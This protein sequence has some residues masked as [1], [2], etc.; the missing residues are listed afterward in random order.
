MTEKTLVDRVISF[1]KARK[2][3]VE[4]GEVNCIPLPFE[5]FRSEIPGIEQ[6]SYYLVS[7]ST[8]SGKSQLSN[9]LFIYNTIF[10]SFYNRDKV[11]PKI[12]YYPLE[13][14]PEVITLR[15]MSFLLYT[16]SNGKCRISP[17]DLKSTDSSKPLP[18]SVIDLLESSLYKEI[19][20]Y[21]ESVIEFQTSRNPTGV[22]KELK[23]YAEN[24]GTTYYKSITTKDELGKDI[25]RKKFDYYTPN[26][27]NEYVFII[28]DHVSLIET[29]KGLSL[30]ESINKLSEYLIIFRNRYNYIPVVVQQ[31]SLETTNLDAFKANKIRPTM[32]GLSD[33]KYTG[34]DCTVMLG[35]T[36]PHSFEIPAYLGYDITKLLGNA[37][38]L[39]V[40]L[41][42]N[43][44]SNGICPLYFDGAVNYFKEMPLP[45][46][47]ESMGNIY[48][49]LQKI[50]KT[51]VSFFSLSIKN[52]INKLQSSFK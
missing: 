41:N 52:I 26:N 6:G 49:L 35:I 27:P 16:L 38:F 39:E 15:F 17:T 4:K 45:T 3:R 1:I 36:N 19:L 43:G 21:Y 9:Y 7:G 13:E 10:Y 28:V 46:D 34:K 14:T 23:E 48:L 20:T 11:T 30:R 37:R 51:G 8:K 32:A 40:V 12:F 47:K 5:R 42:R 2:D 22:W 29:E 31:Q 44:Q 24:N 33:S 18:Q 25:V 50:R